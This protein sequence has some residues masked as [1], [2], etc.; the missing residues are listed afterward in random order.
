MPASAFAVLDAPSN[1]PVGRI[2][3]ECVSGLHSVIVRSAADESGSWRFGSDCFGPAPHS[4]RQISQPAGALEQL[5]ISFKVVE[6]RC[7]AG[8]QKD[9]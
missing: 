2:K 3:S 1:H 6:S 5:T 9:G 4:L 7:C 8:D